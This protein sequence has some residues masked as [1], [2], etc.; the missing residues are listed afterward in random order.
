MIHF[1]PLLPTFVS[2]LPNRIHVNT[3]KQIKRPD[4]LPI[5]RRGRD[6]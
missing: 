2:L 5:H 4:T 3:N 6:K 1:L